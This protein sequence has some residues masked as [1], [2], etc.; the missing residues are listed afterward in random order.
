MSDGKHKFASWTI[1]TCCVVVLFVALWL[2]PDPRG[3]GTHQQLRIPGTGIGLPPCTMK[4]LTGLP[5]ATCGMTTS[6]AHAVRGHWITAFHAHPFGLVLFLVALGAVVE[7]VISLRKNRPMFPYAW[8]WKRIVVAGI[9][10]WACAWGW[11]IVEALP[12]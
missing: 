11:K 9:L 4:S 2:D 10:V 6:F 1:L 7:S 5:C 8:P 12:G 3:F